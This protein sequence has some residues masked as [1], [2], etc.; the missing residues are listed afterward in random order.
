[1]KKLICA[2][3]LFTGM[4]PAFAADGPL[5]IRGRA[6]NML[7]DNGNSTTSVVPS[8]GRVEVNDKI[9]PEV[10]FTYFITRNIAAELILTYPQKH[11]VKFAGSNI[12]TL[13]HLPPTLTVQYHFLPDGTVRPYA[14]LGVNYT[15]FMNVNLNARPALGQDAPIDVDR[16][17]FG[18]AAQV[19]ADFR[20]AP[21]WFINVDVKYVQIKADNVRI[22]GGS[23]AGT[24]VTDLKVDP[25]LLSLG[26]GYRF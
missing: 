3:A 22:T 14:G 19:G 25:W 18:L 10:D 6:L 16:S 1:M 12:G 11:D 9:F 15:R 13:K 24:K 26:V 20:L 7:V 4:G 5:M 2:A 17:S 8:L 23:L 21:N